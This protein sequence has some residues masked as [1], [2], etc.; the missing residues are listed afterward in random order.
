MTPESYVMKVCPIDIPGSGPVKGGSAFRPLLFVTMA[1]RCLGF[2]IVLEFRLALVNANGA[3][4]RSKAGDKSTSLGMIPRLRS[5]NMPSWMSFSVIGGGS[6]KGS[7]LKFFGRILL[8]PIVLPACR[9][10]MPSFSSS[11]LLM[12]PCAR[13]Y[14]NWFGF[15]MPYFFRRIL[16]P[17]WFSGSLVKN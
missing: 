11:M 13:P 3:L 6:A 7:S 15:V 9:Y 1:E 17:I 14:G 10:P 5:E 4:P 12:P 16:W 8:G 2:W